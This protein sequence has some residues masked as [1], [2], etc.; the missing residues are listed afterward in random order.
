MEDFPDGV[1]VMDIGPDK[2]SEIV[3]KKEVRELRSP[4]TDLN[5]VPLFQA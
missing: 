2:E 5:V 1:V 4:I 3:N